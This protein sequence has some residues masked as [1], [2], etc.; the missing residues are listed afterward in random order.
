MLE[1]VAK[2]TRSRFSRLAMT[3]KASLYLE[4]TKRHKLEA[5]LA[6]N[7]VVLEQTKREKDKAAR[8]AVDHLLTTVYPDSIYYFQS[9]REGVEGIKKR[10]L[11]FDFPILDTPSTPMLKPMEGDAYLL[12]KD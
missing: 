1:L 7:D 11:D 10:I 8:V 2:R 3:Y 4:R 5:K 9:S 12:T 6:E